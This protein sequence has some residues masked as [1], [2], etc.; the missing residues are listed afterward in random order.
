[1]LYF[2]QF[3]MIF[4]EWRFHLGK[5]PTDYKDNFEN[6]QDYGQLRCLTRAAP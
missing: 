6:F 3:D 5:A 2:Q 1:M 4:Q